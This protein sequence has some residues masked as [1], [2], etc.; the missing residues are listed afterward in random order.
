MGKSE[1]EKEREMEKG[2][3]ERKERNGNDGRL[4]K[5]VGK[6]RK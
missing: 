1:M 5:R 3:I 6:R 4:N 2:S